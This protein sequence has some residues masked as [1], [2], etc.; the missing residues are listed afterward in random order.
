MID[1]ISCSELFKSDKINT[2]YEFLFAMALA[3]ECG[4]RGEVLDMRMMKIRSK[5]MLS[6]NDIQYMHYLKSI[7]CISDGSDTVY[8]YDDFKDLSYIF[9]VDFITEDYDVLFEDKGNEYYWCTDYA[10]KKYSG[11]YATDV[12]KRLNIGDTIM[13]LAAHMLISFFLGEREERKIRFYFKNLEVKT[14]HLYLDLLACCKKIESLRNRVILDF[15]DI[16]LDSI[17]DLDFYIHY[18]CALHAD[19]IKKWS[20]SE[21]MDFFKSYGLKK[22]S[23]VALYERSRMSNNN[24]LGV[25]TWAYIIRIDDYCE[26]LNSGAGWYVTR[27]CVN[28]TIEESDDDYYGID[29]EYRDC[30]SDLLNPKLPSSKAYLDFSSTGIGEYFYDESYIMM[31]LERGEKVVKKVSVDGKLATV[32]MD[33]IDAIYWIMKEYGVSFDEDL[34][35]SY[36]NDGKPLL[37]DLYDCTPVRFAK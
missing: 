25:I 31:P 2:Y 37:Y 5:S 35:K 17:E 11:K 33:E 28:K 7:G 36:Y 27:F 3:A 18:N 9:P 12:L 29:E 8:D 13:N 10:Y 30:F 26:D 6:N 24:P 16:Y 21:K 19:S 4:R 15:D 22:G 14:V 1:M 34:Y 20:L 23:I 32:E